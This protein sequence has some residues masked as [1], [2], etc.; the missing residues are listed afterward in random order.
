MVRL[1]LFLTILLTTNHKVA[2]AGK[3]TLTPDEQSKLNNNGL[4]VSVTP[5]PKGA[6][7]MVQAIIDIPVP[8]A[9]LWHTMLDCNGANKFIKGLQKCIILSKDPKGKWDVREHIVSWLSLMPNT[10]SEFKSVYVKEK[11]IKFKRTGGDL[12]TLE[13]EWNL[14]PSAKGKHTRLTYMAR[15]DPGTI[16]PS[17]LIRSAVESDLPLTLKALKKEAIRRNRLSH[18]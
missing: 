4:F 1:A 14:L 17:S 2:N 9:I 12:K 7:G 3:I 11:N 18:Q 16:L 5:D 6:A 8:P 15:V 13:G 10:R